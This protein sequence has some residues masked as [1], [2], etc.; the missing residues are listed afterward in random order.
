[1]RKSEVVRRSGVEVG[2][3]LAKVG[4]VLTRHLGHWGARRNSEIDRSLSLLTCSFYE[5][6]KSI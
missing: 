1:V 5:I 4:T 2:H 3:G 6:D